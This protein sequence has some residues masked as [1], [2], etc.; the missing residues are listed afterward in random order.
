MS[1]GIVSTEATPSNRI[2]MAATTNVYG[3]FRASLTIH[4]VEVFAAPLVHDDSK[5]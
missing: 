4:M 1:V 5:D 3:R 2:K